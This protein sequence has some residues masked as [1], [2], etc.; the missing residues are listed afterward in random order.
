MTAEEVIGYY[1]KLLR[2]I[3]III[4]LQK[5]SFAL[6]LLLFLT[7]T[8]RRNCFCQNDLSLFLID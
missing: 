6:F 4:C 7:A 2:I 1:A 8:I 5:Y 3:L